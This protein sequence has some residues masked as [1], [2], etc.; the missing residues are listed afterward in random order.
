MMGYIIPQTKHYINVHSTLFR[1]KYGVRLCYKLQ[2]ES[3]P[4]TRSDRNKVSFDSNENGKDN[5]L[6]SITNVN[7]FE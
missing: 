5:D 4:R 6:Y 2:N 3:V 7:K 1:F